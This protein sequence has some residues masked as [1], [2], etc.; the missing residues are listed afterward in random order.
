MTIC[1][2][3][4]AYV[5]SIGRELVSAKY[6][7]RHTACTW[8]EPYFS[9][10]HPPRLFKTRQEKAMSAVNHAHCQLCA[11]WSSSDP[12]V[13]EITAYISENVGKVHISEIYDQT[14]ASLLE[15]CDITVSKK[16]VFLHITEH[17]T[18]QRVVL[19]NIMRNLVE[20]NKVVKNSCYLECEETGKHT[21]DTKA[22][23]MYLKT[24][25][26]ITNIYKMENYKTH[27]R[28]ES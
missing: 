6:A 21:I 7:A 22:L 16:S 2:S 15:H 23:G 11:L 12:T 8:R 17:T 19:G 5:H 9:M 27:A 25:D 24:V 13:Q 1:T 14:S 28:K 10:P 3:V 26:Q 4:T 20:L 18:D